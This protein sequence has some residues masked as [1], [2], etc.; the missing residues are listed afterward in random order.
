[1]K[2]EL[3]KRTKRR[4]YEFWR[5]RRNVIKKSANGRGKSEWKGEGA[6]RGRDEEER[7]SIGI[8]KRHR[9]WPAEIATNDCV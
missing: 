1:M 4:T 9:H 5:Q 6:G 2:G 7:T 3:G 8:G